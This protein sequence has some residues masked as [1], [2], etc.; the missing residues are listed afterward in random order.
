V[1]LTSPQHNTEAAIKGKAEQRQQPWHNNNDNPSTSCS[2]GLCT[3]RAVNQP[4]ADLLMH[5]Q[6]TCDSLRSTGRATEHPPTQC[7]IPSHRHVARPYT[8]A[9]LSHFPGHRRTRRTCERDIMQS[10]RAQLSHIARPEEPRALGSPWIQHEA[11]DARAPGSG[12]S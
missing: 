5:P 1:C 2:N 8:R 10:L 4:Y 12:R 6:L 7:A 3:V 9:R 11:E